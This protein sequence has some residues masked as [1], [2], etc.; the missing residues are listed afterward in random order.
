MDADASVLSYTYKFPGGT[1]NS[2][3]ARMGDGQACRSPLTSVTVDPDQASTDAACKSSE[4]IHT[5]VCKWRHGFGAT[6]VLRC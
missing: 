3:A 2:F 1:A 6:T 4:R 5:H